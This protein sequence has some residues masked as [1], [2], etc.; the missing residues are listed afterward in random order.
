MADCCTPH[1]YEI[2]PSTRPCEPQADDGADE[3]ARR[4][5][6][7]EDGIRQHHLAVNPDGSRRFSM[8]MDRELWDLLDEDDG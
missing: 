3:L 1:R 7:L 8:E 4:V 5:R 6:Q 2:W